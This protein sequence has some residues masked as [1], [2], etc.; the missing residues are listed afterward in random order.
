MKKV[1]IYTW[2]YCPFCIRAKSLLNKKNIEFIEGFFEKSLPKINHK[3]MYGDRKATLINIDC[4][5]YE[6]AV[7]VFSHISNLLQE[8]TILYID[9]YFAGYKGNPF[10]G[11]SG[12]MKKWIKN[13]EWELEPY[14]DVGITGKSYVVYRI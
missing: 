6:S 13:V 4:D 2:Q 9:D 3:E 7:P 8:G 10:K 14:R 1:E 12:A 5:L 11:V